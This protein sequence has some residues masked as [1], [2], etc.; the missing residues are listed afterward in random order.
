MIHEA[1]SAAER[2][3]VALMLTVGLIAGLVGL[4][5]LGLCAAIRWAWMRA[6]RRLYGPVRASE[7]PDGLRDAG[8]A[9]E[10]SEGHTEPQSYREAA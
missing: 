6:R 8:D 3:F 9:P 2:V 1:I 7:G 5:V 4:L 10:P